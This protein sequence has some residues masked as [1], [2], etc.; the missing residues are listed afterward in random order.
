LAAKGGGS[1]ILKLGMIASLLVA[2][3]AG[4]GY[5]YGVAVPERERAR[6][7]A[8]QLDQARADAARRD[9]RLS[10]RRNAG[11]RRSRSPPR[12]PT[13][14]ASPPPAPHTNRPGWPNAGA[15][16]MKAHAIGPTACP[17]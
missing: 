2:A 17:S 13:K 9:W 3:A 6:E 8:R 11:L 12:L 7:A 14:P 10:K 15:S 5:Y 4:G 1:V 16:R